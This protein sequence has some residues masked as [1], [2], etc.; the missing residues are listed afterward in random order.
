MKE[1]EIRFQAREKRKRKLREALIKEG[2]IEPEKYK[3]DKGVP[4]S[5]YRTLKCRKLINR[6]DKGD[7]VLL[8]T[9][10]M[11]KA[12]CCA[13]KEMGRYAIYKIEGEGYR[14]WLF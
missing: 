13:A 2:E 14:V 10:I 4:L 7:S 9:D 11:A 6:I 1:L 12:V 3:I 5:G 8:L